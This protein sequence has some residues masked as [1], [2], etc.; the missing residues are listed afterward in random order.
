MKLASTLD[1]GGQMGN[2]YLVVANA[3]DKVP[4]QKLL[5]KLEFYGFGNPF[6]SW[7]ED[8]LT[9]RRHRIM[10]GGFST[11]WKPVS[12]AVPQGSLIGPILFLI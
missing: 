2:I 10:I 3:F 6:L 11:D 12:S 5:Y 4:H 1:I 7:I 9:N 8:Y